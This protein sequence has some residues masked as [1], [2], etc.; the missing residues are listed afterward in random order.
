[1]KEP[2][3]I[4]ESDP[5]ITEAKI[6]D[7][8]DVEN[9]DE[10]KERQG[11]LK[12]IRKKLEVLPNKPVITKTDFIEKSKEKVAPRVAQRKEYTK[13]VLNNINKKS[14]A[15][16]S[17]QLL[18][19][20]NIDN[21]MNKYLKQLI[22]H[23]DYLDE[24]GKY[25]LYK[26]LKQYEQLSKDPMKL[27]AEFGPNAVLPNI[28]ITE[29]V[30]SFMKSKPKRPLNFLLS[31]MRDKYRQE[32]NMPETPIIDDTPKPMKKPMKTRKVYNPPKINEAPII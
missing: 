12:K 4:L 18:I 26:N 22:N 14:I 16:S 21:W 13:N 5:N 11:K 25:F 10:I 6:I 31:E 8:G 30:K 23:F 29:K 3:V 24:N 9:V 15:L 32:Y 28:E 17:R 27:F 19:Q 1:M 2:S 7:K 20:N